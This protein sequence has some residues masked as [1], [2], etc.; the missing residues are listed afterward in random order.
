MQGTRHSQ[1][2]DIFKNVSCDED[3][4]VINLKKLP[5]NL[6]YLLTLADF[7]LFDLDQIPVKENQPTTGPFVLSSLSKD[8]ALFNRNPYYPE[9]LRANEIPNVSIESYQAKDTPQLVDSLDIAKD[10]F[11]YLYG[12]SLTKSDLDQI[13]SKGF[14]LEVQ[15]SE[16]L[17]Y[18]GFQ[19]HVAKEIVFSS[20]LTW[21]AFGIYFHETQPRA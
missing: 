18:F 10:H 9:E 12:H 15:P 14:E 7:S 19:L 1:L 2:K 6:A 17:T 16:W 21:I 8:R 13:E 4:I 20:G 11:I 5:V 3:A